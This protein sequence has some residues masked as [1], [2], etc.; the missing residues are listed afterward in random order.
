MPILCIASFKPISEV[1]QFQ[2]LWNAAQLEKL[3]IVVKSCETLRLLWYKRAILFIL[4]WYRNAIELRA[5]YQCDLWQTDR[6]DAL[7]KP[8]AKEAQNAFQSTVA[9]FRRQF[10]SELASHIRA[11]HASL[12]ARCDWRWPQILLTNVLN[13]SS[14]QRQSETPCLQL[15]V[16]SNENLFYQHATDKF[17]LEQNGCGWT[18]YVHTS[19]RWM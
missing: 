4:K 19:V 12:I 18:E 16:S 6:R 10:D 5:K 13:N 1:T 7:R 17:A 8:T 14:I 9:E 2:M 15:L 3:E 11:S